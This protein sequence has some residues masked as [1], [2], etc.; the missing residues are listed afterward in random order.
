MSLRD[1]IRKSYRGAL[2]VLPAPVEEKVF[3]TLFKLRGRPTLYRDPAQHPMRKDRRGSITFS[4]D[5]ELAWAWR[6]S[7]KAASESVRLGLLER[8]NVPPI[9]EAFD[10]YAIPA[11]WATVGH[12]FLDHCER[13]IDG[14][15]HPEMP[16][17]PAFETRWWKFAGDDWF[18]HDPCTDVHKDP[19]WY[20]PDLIAL[21]RASRTGHEIGCHSFSHAGFGS[22]CP[23]E[24]ALAELAACRKIFE[25]EGIRAR[26]FVFPGNDFGNYPAAVETGFDI[27]RAFPV[28]EVE[29]SLPIHRQDGLWALHA[30][31]YVQ[32]GNVTDPKKLAAHC[33]YLRWYA[34]K[35][36]RAGMNAHFWL[37][38][39]IPIAQVTH[40]LVPLL[41]YCADLRENKFV[42]I[43]SMEQLVNSTVNHQLTSPRI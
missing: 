3:E 31:Y 6:F 21:I 20:A 43:L 10:K 35:A 36:A 34:D 8:E 40:V 7:K 11:T 33:R 27:V 14:R 23:H 17:L 15:A 2:S 4:L 5:F 29:I 30:S 32:M 41:D 16:Q 39:S 1:T 13:G 19:A 24:V 28:P 9:L 12:L 25:R 38:P 26:S 42:E 37:H 22:Y 18:R